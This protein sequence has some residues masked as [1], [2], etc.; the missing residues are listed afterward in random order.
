MRKRPVLTEGQF[1]QQVAELK[2][3][4]RDSVSPFENDTPAKQAARKERGKTDLL[5][6]FATYLPHYFSSEFG[7]FHEEWQEITELEDQFALVGAPREH[8][9]STFFTL[10]NPVHKICYKLKKFIWPCSDTHEQATAFSLQIKLEFEDN[11]RIKHDF[12]KLKTKNWSDDEFETSNG[13]MVMAR[14]RGDKVRGIRYRQYRPDM[15]IFDDMEND[16]TVENPRTTKKIINWIRG[17]VL[18][19]LGKGYSAIMVGNLF[20]PLSAISKL[21]A[22]EDEEGRPRYTSKV[23]DAILDEGTPEER[24]LWPAAWP[25]E[26]L[27]RKKHDVGTYSFNKEM[28]NKVGTEDSPFPE[29]TVS[30]YERIELLSVPLIYA[31]GVDPASTSGSKSDFRSVVTWGLERVKMEFYCMHA[32]IKRRSIGEFFAAAYA[33]YDL[34]PGTVVVEENMLKEFLHEAILNYAKEVGRYLPWSPIN[35]TTSKIDAR[36]IGTCEYLWEHKKMKFEKRH[37]DQKILEEQF[38]YIMNPSVHDDGPD[39]TEMAIRHLQNNGGVQ[40]AYHPVKKTD[41][42]EMTRSVVCTAGLGRG[43]GLW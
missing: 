10:G 34:Y 5:Y 4:I 13:V 8:A 36:I 33:Q 23:Y 22:E 20:H 37:S 39:A 32:W 1:D 18:G 9:K 6:F 11:P 19:S 7:E 41:E 14:G 3:W 30:Y 42:R 12:G 35:H 38:I 29:E 21:I 27:M 31:T 28:R 26:R 15:A 17:A 24:P 40:Y 43:A 2:K 25:M 16:E